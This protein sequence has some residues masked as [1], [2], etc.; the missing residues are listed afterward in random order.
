LSLEARYRAIA[1]K[2]PAGVTLV[3]V[4]K[5][6]PASAIAELYKLGHRDFGENYAQELVAKAEELHACYDLRWHFIGHLQSNKAKL[7][8]PHLHSVHSVDSIKLARELA[9]RWKE[10]DRDGKLP[11]FLEVNIDG[12]SS[13]TGLM[14]DQVAS[15]AER[16]ADEF[17]EL[18]LQGLMCIP[19]PEGAG[20]AFAHLRALELKCQPHTRGKLSMGMTQD[21]EQA[22]REGATHVRVGT[23][24]FGP[25]PD[26]GNP[27]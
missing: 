5:G 1:S 19:N 20:A 16:I 18:E 24:I 7:L 25:R 6:Q 21:F 27:A 12:E 26:S 22:I 9:K 13:K 14:P 4:S 8:M 23:A 11:T 10:Q 3:A 2:V 17:R 15:L